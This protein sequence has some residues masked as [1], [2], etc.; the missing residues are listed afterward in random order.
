MIP[1][2]RQTHRTPAVFVSI[3]SD[4]PSLR[5]WRGRR[6][7]NALGRT[8]E[9]AKSG[10]LLSQP[11]ARAELSGNHADLLSPPVSHSK[12][13]SPQSLRARCLTTVR[14]CQVGMMWKSWQ[15]DICKDNW[16]ANNF[17]LSECP[18]QMVCSDVQRSCFQLLLRMH[19][20]KDFKHQET[21]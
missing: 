10:N 2:E 9:E 1:E 16:E 17:D 18:L 21:P 15:N 5:V 4:P 8:L 7:P 11:F 20:C 13:S 19:S 6:P 14:S 12:S 3:A